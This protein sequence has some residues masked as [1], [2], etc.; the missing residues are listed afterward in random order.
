[1]VELDRDEMSE[2]EFNRMMEKGLEQAKADE[3]VSVS[4][5]FASLRATEKIGAFS[6]SQNSKETMYWDAINGKF[7]TIFEGQRAAILHI[8]NRNIM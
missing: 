7:K 1:M 6:F 8:I 4:D 5:A 3:S 2:V